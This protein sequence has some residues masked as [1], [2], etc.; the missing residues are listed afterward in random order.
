MQLHALA[1]TLSRMGCIAWT[2]SVPVQLPSTHQPDQ[3]NQLA[4]EPALLLSGSRRDGAAFEATSSSSSVLVDGVSL[5]MSQTT[6][7]VS[8]PSNEDIQ[9]LRNAFAELYGVDRNI[10]KSLTLLNQAIERWQGQPPDELAGLY[11]VRGDA[12]MLASSATDAASD[13]D[14]ALQLLETPE[15]K[16][17][18]DPAEMTSALLGRARAVKS[19]K[20]SSSPE[21]LKQAAED[22]RKGILLSSRE[23][24]DTE[25]ELIEDGASR[26]PYAAWEWGTVLR[27][28]GDYQAAGKAHKLA[29]NAFEDIGDP[30]RAVISLIDTGIDVADRDTKAAKTIL[31]QAIGKTNGIEGGDAALLELV[32]AKEGEGR[33]ALASIEWDEG[34]REEAENVMGKA[35]IR[36]D[37]LEA[38]RA[39]KANSNNNK[40]TQGGT[41]MPPPPSALPFSIDDDY[42]PVSSIYCAKFRDAKFVTEKLDWPVNLQ[43]KVVRLEKLQV[44]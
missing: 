15:G 34:N 27:R 18:A 21:A 32:I 24:W 39:K 28:I 44:G 19:Q 36:L 29:A 4:A 12:N 5:W 2:V 26:N 17:N 25:D 3:M 7:A 13:Y 20:S 11:R 22:Y 6:T 23:G 16:K 38:Y 42:P 37:Q 35:C 10:P 14:K 9:L 31:K 41:D 8:P 43:K 40:D 33:M 1:V 30:A